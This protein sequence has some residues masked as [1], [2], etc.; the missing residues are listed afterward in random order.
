MVGGILYALE[1]LYSL[2]VMRKIY[3]LY[4][5]RGHSGTSLAAVAGGAGGISTAVT[6][7]RVTGRI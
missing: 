5:G 4:R 2:F 3:T 6:A 1:A 7:A